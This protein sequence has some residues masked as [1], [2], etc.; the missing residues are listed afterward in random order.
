MVYLQFSF[1][2]RCHH[3]NRTACRHGF[4]DCNS[5][6]ECSSKENFHCYVLWNNATNSTMF[7]EYKGCF[8][9]SDLA[10]QSQNE[11]IDKGD[12]K[13]QSWLYC[14]C[15]G[16]LCNNDFSWKPT[17][18]PPTLNVT[19]SSNDDDVK[20][21]MIYVV[22]PVSLVIVLLVM[23]L[24][25]RRKISYF[26]KKIPSSDLR[27]QSPPSPI[28]AK[29]RSISLIEVKARGKF[30][31]VWKATDIKELVAVKIMAPQEKQSWMTEQEI[32][33][34]PLMN[35]E[36]ILRFIAA[37]RRGDVQVT[38]Y[39]L[40]TEFHELGSL[41]DFLKHNTVTW[42]QLSRIAFT[43][44]RGL[45]HLH[46]E[47]PSEKIECYKPAVAHRDFK[48]S[49]VLLKS[50]LSAC[51]ADFGLALIFK[52]SRSCG[53][54]HGQV[55]TRR[56]MAPEILEGAINFSRDSFLRIDMYACGLVLWELLS[57]C[58]SHQGTVTDFKLPFEKEVGQHPTLEDI[59]E[60]VVHKKM[61]PVIE[62]S[63]R[64]HS[65]LNV[66]C[67][68]V[69]ELWDHDAE[70]RVSA[71]CVMER[72]SIQCQSIPSLSPTTP[73]MYEV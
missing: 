70:A 58:S 62:K 2:L 23:M 3:Y 22:F 18:K 12:L 4:E 24:L 67:D 44:A 52:P 33:K 27:P 73:L 32:Y 20:S 54:T 13:N 30:G 48:S 25:K 41:H 11:C 7:I 8:I 26:N 37:E 5:I 45:A 50:D 40:I 28:P 69:E 61:R 9:T 63:W 57:R 39:W 72:M 1:G 6:E 55:G 17:P 38:E 51:I 59:Q 31:A 60:V 46:E 71:C 68:T 42:E 47:I 49:N 21:Y 19:S 53:D 15:E 10:C 56:Y 29:S 16:D 34:L 66:L 64:E 43:I 14:C 35:H 36:N 65:G